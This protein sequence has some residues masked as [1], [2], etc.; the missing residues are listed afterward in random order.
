MPFVY[1]ECPERRSITG[2]SHAT[3]TGSSR[4]KSCLVHFFVGPW[5]CQV[6]CSKPCRTLP[7][8]PLTAPPTK[9]PFPSSPQAPPPGWN[10]LWHD[11]VFVL[12]IP[13]PPTAASTSVEGRRL[14]AG[15]STFCCF[16]VIGS[17]SP[18]VWNRPCT[19]TR[20][21]VCLDALL[22]SL[23]PPAVCTA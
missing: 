2:K 16:A 19:H 18:S 6:W 11:P 9:A 23:K 8:S 22:D 10:L 3:G 17:A 7:A 1:M 21:F 4:V 14:L 15:W 5:G 13:L 12:W 20:V